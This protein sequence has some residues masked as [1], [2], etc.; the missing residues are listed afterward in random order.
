MINNNIGDVKISLVLQFYSQVF[1]SGC[2][3]KA[4]VSA[5][6]KKSNHCHCALGVQHWIL[7]S[8]V[9]GWSLLTS[10]ALALALCSSIGEETESQGKPQASP[11]CWGC[12]RPLRCSPKFGAPSCSDLASAAAPEP[13][14]VAVT[15][16]MLAYKGKRDEFR[17]VLTEFLLL[18]TL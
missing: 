12:P 13:F 14:L 16:R 9:P 7:I 8:Y 17:Q 1:Q 18:I 10:R 5:G 4:Q 6:L 11:H 3:Q 15:R 2:L